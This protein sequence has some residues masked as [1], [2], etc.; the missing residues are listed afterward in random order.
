M[1][2][3]DLD[4]QL[5]ADNASISGGLDLAARDGRQ[6]AALMRV[7]REH[8][9][10]SVDEGTVAPLMGFL[11]GH[12]TKSLGRIAQIRLACKK[13]CSHCCRGWVSA[14]APEIFH[15]LNFIDEER[16]P[17]MSAAIVAANAA[18]SGKS[19][20]ERARM[21]VACGFLDNHACSIYEARPVLCRSAVSTNAEICRR[22][23]LE[24]SGEDIP[25]P[26]PYF[27]LSDGYTV[28]LA[29]ALKH[30]GLQHRAFE[31]NSGLKAALDA[32]EAE[33]E[34]LAGGN[35]FP[36]SFQDDDILEEDWVRSIYRSAFG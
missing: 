24:F 7:L 20:E 26:P 3:K 17:S 33:A 18:T 34:W 5:A 14:T 35:V 25:T 19:P 13:G 8:V 28:A 29:C 23:C 10:V 12:Y 22:S 11:Y 4:R 16:S 2:A 27:A 32:P 30:A 21:N 15:A 9:A 1:Q 36:D 6:L 31:Y